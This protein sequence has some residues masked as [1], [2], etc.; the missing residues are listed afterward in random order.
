MRNN[1]IDAHS[2]AW[3]AQVWISFLVSAGMTLM[4]IVLLPVDLWTKGYFLMG[5]LFLTG[6]SFSLA[7]TVRDNQETARLRNRIQAAKTDK[8][9]KEFELHESA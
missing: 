3:N 7:K 2:M 6:S 5:V 9:L 4:G 1:D 8:I